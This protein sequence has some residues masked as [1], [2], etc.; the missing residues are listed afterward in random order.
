MKRVDMTKT[1]EPFVRITSAKDIPTCCVSDTLTIVHYTAPW[2][3]NCPPFAEVLTQL[4]T[5]YAFDWYYV[6]LG[7]VDDATD[8]ADAHSIARLPAVA[9]YRKTGNAVE[10][11]VRQGCSAD[12]I[13]TLLVQH[14]SM[15][16]AGFFNAPD[17]HDF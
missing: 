4:K 9:L 3:P 10:V 11:D 12:Q 14:G 6:D 2:C 8:A 7:R 15:H 17:A 13:K 5:V 1:C 16:Q